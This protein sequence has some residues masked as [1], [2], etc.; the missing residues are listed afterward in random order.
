MTTKD[1]INMKKEII[2]IC[3]LIL[4]TNFVSPLNIAKGKAMGKIDHQLHHS[5]HVPQKENN[6]KWTKISEWKDL[7]YANSGK[8]ILY[9]EQNTRKWAIDFIIYGG[10][11]RFNCQK[12]IV[13]NSN[14]YLCHEPYDALGEGWN[15]FY[16]SKGSTIY[17]IQDVDVNED[18]K[19]MYQVTGIL[20]IQ[21]QNHARIFM[22]DS[23][24]GRRHF[25]LYATLTR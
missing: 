20:I 7:N 5:V 9:Q 21:N 6:N 1:S 25:M 15:T 10:T 14:E 8:Y 23:P 24:K 18:D 3:L 4:V 17:I 2:K 16:L 13:K 22:N 19:G 12:R 11:I